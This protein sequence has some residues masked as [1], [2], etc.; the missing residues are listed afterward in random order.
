MR[1]GGFQK[2]RAVIHRFY[3]QLLLVIVP[4]LNWKVWPKIKLFSPDWAELGYIRVE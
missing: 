1:K 4:S 2:T 3:V